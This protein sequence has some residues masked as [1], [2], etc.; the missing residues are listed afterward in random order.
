KGDRLPDRGSSLLGMNHAVAPY[1][2]LRRA[3][4]VPTVQS[5]GMITRH[6]DSHL[7]RIIQQD[8]QLWRRAGRDRS[9][10]TGAANRSLHWQDGHARYGRPE[11][12]RIRSKSEWSQIHQGANQ[13][14]LDRLHSRL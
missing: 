11:L 8:A 5:A 13:T 14:A 9:G 4:L 2:H 12:A 7:A 10:S 1:L 3:G 6:Y